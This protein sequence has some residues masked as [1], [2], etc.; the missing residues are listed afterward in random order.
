MLI[1][2]ALCKTAYSPSALAENFVYVPRTQY[3]AAQ[4][5]GAKRFFK[6]FGC[7]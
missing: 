7:E 5:E 4:I 2:G 6:K 1:L 3:E